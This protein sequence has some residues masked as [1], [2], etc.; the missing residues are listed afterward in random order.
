MIPPPEKTPNTKNQTKPQNNIIHDTGS[1]QQ[2][3]LAKV[4]IL[5]SITIIRTHRNCQQKF[6]MVSLN[7]GATKASW[8]FSRIKFPQK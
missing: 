7:G 2:N 4:N 1:N 8:H 6:H 5:P 3:V